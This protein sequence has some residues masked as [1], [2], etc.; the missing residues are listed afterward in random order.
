MHSQTAP[1]R[2]RQ[3]DIKALFSLVQRVVDDHH[4][5]LLLPLSLV[6]AKDAAVLL[7]A[8]NVVR[9]RQNGG[10]NRSRGR[11]FRATSEMRGEN[12]EKESLL[13]T[14]RL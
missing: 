3:S 11:S 12:N 10:G 2:Q 8:G 1:N 4:T 14:S 13:K 5:T 6:K 9:V 7:R